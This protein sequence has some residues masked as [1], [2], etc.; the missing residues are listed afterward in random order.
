L[1]PFFLIEDG[2]DVDSFY[3]VSKFGVERVWDAIERWGETLSEGAL[4]IGKDGGAIRFI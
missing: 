1:S 4:P 2:F 3:S